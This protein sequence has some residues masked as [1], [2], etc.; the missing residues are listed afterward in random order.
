MIFELRTYRIKKGCMDKWVQLMDDTVIPFQKEKGMRVIGS[1]VSLERDDEYVWMRRFE[2]EEQRGE[3]YD[4][5][6]GSD[7]W[8]NRIRPAMGD[9]LLRE[10][11]DVRLLEATPGSAL[12]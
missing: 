9:M 5:V 6:Y 11:I 10:E 4:A 1:F 2:N 12:Q 8:K 3:L 7:A